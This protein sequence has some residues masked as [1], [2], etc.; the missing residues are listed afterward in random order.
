MASELH[1]YWCAILGV[2]PVGLDASERKTVDSSH[3]LRRGRH[4]GGA[5]SEGQLLWSAIES[6]AVPRFE[7]GWSP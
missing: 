7:M 6:I 5:Y 2:E 3:S 1:E 4:V